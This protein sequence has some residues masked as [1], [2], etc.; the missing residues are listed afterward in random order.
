MPPIQPPSITQDKTARPHVPPCIP[1]WTEF[2]LPCL[3]GFAPRPYLGGMERITAACR[4]LQAFTGTGTTGAL[5]VVSL[6]AALIVVVVSAFTLVDAP[7]WAWLSYGI[8]MLAGLAALA[9][10]PRRPWVSALIV[11][12]AL[13]PSALGLFVPEYGH[14]AGLEAV[15]LLALALLVQAA[16]ARA[17][18]LSRWLGVAGVVVAAAVLAVGSSWLTRLWWQQQDRWAAATQGGDEDFTGLE[19]FQPFVPWSE[20]GVAVFAVTAA[21]FLLPWLIGL[22]LGRLSRA[23]LHTTA[24]P[25]ADAGGWRVKERDGAAATVPRT[26]WGLAVA[27]VTGIVAFGFLAL[28]ALRSSENR[29]YYEPTLFWLALTITVVS[30]VWFWPR[31]GLLVMTLLLSFLVVGPSLVGPYSYLG[32]DYDTGLII[33]VLLAIALA[34]ARLRPGRSWW[35]WCGAYVGVFACWFLVVTAN[36]LVELTP[37]GWA[38]YSSRPSDVTWLSIVSVIGGLLLGTLAVGMGYCLRLAARYRASR[39][40]LA[41][42]EREL[43]DAE[44]RHALSEDR[45]AIAGD[46][47]DVLAHSLTV[48]VAQGEGALVTSNGERAASVRNMVDVARSSLLDVRALIE[49]LDGEDPALPAPTLEDLPRL[50]ETSRNAG[51]PVVF[52]EF[53]ERTALSTSRQL[54]VYRIVQE[55]LTN[56][57]KHGGSGGEAA[58]GLDW[59]GSEPGLSLTIAS[60]RAPDHAHGDVPGNRRGLTGMQARA[61]LAG[62]W[63]VAGPDDAGSDGA[64]AGRGGWLVTAFIPATASATAA[65]ATTEASR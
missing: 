19:S 52:Q 32:T 50:V 61:E 24:S 59:R 9:T 25:S 26:H 44:Q 51:M 41:A 36:I 17:T 20:T 46:I 12:L 22:Q 7:T 56:A 28:W 3:P 58:L 37:D 23:G 31:P 10:A 16:S 43:Q 65:S 55:A 29:G 27:V 15:I 1:L 6:P 49:R 30:A 18:R 4:K 5:A 45:R 47:H 40:E 8:L 54:A 64:G 14:G 2:A 39:M 33:A 63:L 35:W 62:G 21:S 38:I 57:L 34:A 42:T 48:I 53:G 11:T 13:V 60:T